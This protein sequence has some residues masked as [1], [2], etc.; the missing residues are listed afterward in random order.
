[1]RVLI[2]DCDG[3]HGIAVQRGVRSAFPDID[4][5][6]YSADRIRYAHYYQYCDRYVSAI[7]LSE[8]ISSWRP[9]M[10]IPVGGL[11]VRAVASLSP[12][13]AVLPP[14]D[15][16]NRTYS[17]RDV[18]A[19]SREV[20]V[21]TPLTCQV[22]SVEAA[23]DPTIPYPCVL[24]PI[25]ETEAKFVRYVDSPSSLAAAVRSTIE[26]APSGLLAQEQIVG[27]GAGVCA[28]YDRGAAKRL[29]C[30]RRV[31]EWP[32]TGG[33]STAA[34]AIRDRA[35]RDAGLAVLDALKWHGV[36]MVEFKL[37]STTG[38]PVFIELNGKF[39]GSYELALS[40]G[41]NFGADL[42]RLF[43]GHYLEFSEDYDERAQFFWPL[44]GDL[45]TI[46]AMGRPHLL[47][48]YWGRDAH[49]NLG[50]SWRAEAIKAL[51][52]TYKIGKLVLKK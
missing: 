21:R 31:R 28:L 39:W 11:S 43:C 18:T 52:T 16:L 32:L 6:G 22:G 5:I 50:Q 35:L 17:K 47:R 20:G 19:L 30:Y 51:A 48:E 38:Q 2:T 26:A 23:T 14:I 36:A 40:A 49:T 25:D 27:P 24:K 42:V 7:P 41:M 8:A 37:E 44:D 4:L 15:V 46:L 29:F 12:E 33:S 13:L 45:R 3:K 34:E 1:M 9:D 10:V